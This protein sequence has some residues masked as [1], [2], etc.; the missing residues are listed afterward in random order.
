MPDNS[1]SN[2]LIAKQ[3]MPY[4]FKP[5]IKKLI[6]GEEKWVLSAVE[7]SESV[8]VE[9]GQTISKLIK[10]QGAALVGKDVYARFGNTFPLLIKF[11]EANM[12]LSVQVHPSD[13]I[14]RKYGQPWG[15]T[16]MWYALPPAE[17]HAKIYCGLNKHITP[18]EYK[19]MVEDKTIMSAIAEYDVQ[20]GDCFFIPA[21]RIHS[22]GHGC[23]VCEVQQTS[24]TTY[25]IYDFDRVDKNGNRRELHTEKAAESINFDDMMTDGRTAL[26]RPKGK[27]V[28]QLIS[29]PYFTTNALHVEKELE[30]DYSS[31]D[32]FVCFVCT[33]GEGCITT[34]FSKGDLLLLPA[35]TKKVKYT[36]TFKA[37]EVFIA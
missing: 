28:S 22:I 21:G 31:I 36:G 8:C 26:N 14:A 20:D 24:D 4:T 18:D 33:E 27:D 13:D 37:L 2:K 15:K 6:W 17:E 3:P 34:P 23:R 10:E 12:D 29:C 30:R 32:S 1:S 7:G 5:I 11:I 25:R 19:Q 35:A 16:E 9:T